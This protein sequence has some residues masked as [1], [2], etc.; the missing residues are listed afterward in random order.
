L[1]GELHLDIDA[2]IVIAHSDNEWAARHGTNFGFHPLVRLLDR[3]EIAST[4][5]WWST[6]TQNEEAG[7]IQLPAARLRRFRPNSVTE[8]P[9]LRVNRSVMAEMVVTSSVLVE[10]DRGASRTR[11]LRFEHLGVA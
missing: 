5:S 10:A 11:Q 2:T 9:D 3:P 8:P 1:S 6:G 7:R 4:I